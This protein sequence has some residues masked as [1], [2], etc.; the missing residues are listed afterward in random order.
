M[1]EPNTYEHQHSENLTEVQKNHSTGQGSIDL[2]E[3]KQKCIQ[4]IVSK[5]KLKRRQQSTDVDVSKVVT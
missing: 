4:Q 1:C 5:W 3:D 2:K